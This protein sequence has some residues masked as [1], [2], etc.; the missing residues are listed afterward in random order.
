MVTTHEPSAG[1]GCRCTISTI[2]SVVAHGGTSSSPGGRASSSRSVG[3]K[4]RRAFPDW[5]ALLKL[6]REAERLLERPAARMQRLR[7]LDR[8]CRRDAAAAQHLAQ[9]EH[10]HLE[11]HLQRALRECRA[12]DEGVAKLGGERRVQ[13]DG[14]RLVVERLQAPL[15]LPRH[16][17]PSSS[18][19]S[20]A[21]RS[22]CSLTRTFSSS[23]HS[24]ACTERYLTSSRRSAAPSPS[25]PAA[26]S[27]RCPAGR[28]PPPRW[29]RGPPPRSPPPGRAPPG[30]VRPAV[31]HELFAWP[32]RRAATAGTGG[33][34]HRRRRRRH[35]PWPPPPPRGS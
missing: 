34:H 9:R 16:V 27:L 14:R 12:S 20:S 3:C 24:L 21:A 31:N 30:R 32:L 13:P 6:V 2:G 19:S 29:P 28:H 22:A 17:R 26:P 25:P 5:R 4:K 35:R 7:R 23:Q 10:L 11:A 33:A 18:A 15:L 1:V 8:Q